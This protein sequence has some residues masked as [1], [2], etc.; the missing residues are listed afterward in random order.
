MPPAKLSV[1]IPTYNNADQVRTLLDR[2]HG[3]G[4]IDLAIGEVP[5]QHGAHRGATAVGCQNAGHVG[6]LLL[7]EALR[8]SHREWHAVGGDAVIADDN[9]F[10]LRSE[11]QREC[12]RYH[13]KPAS[14][15]HLCHS[16]RLICS[17][18]IHATSYDGRPIKV[19]GNPLHPENLVTKWRGRAARGGAG[20]RGVPP[21][22]SRPV[23]PRIHGRIER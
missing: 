21:R 10:P 11:R 12:E 18:G 4:R 5:A 23:R 13:G 15:G 1:L 2:D 20:V 22:R 19:D 16:L 14:L 3:R 8:Q 17:V 9:L 6:A 7:E